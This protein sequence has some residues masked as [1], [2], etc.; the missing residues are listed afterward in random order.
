[1]AERT[2]EKI[3]ETE[4]LGRKI[5]MYGSIENPLFLARDVADW[6]DYSKRK[7]GSYQTGNMLKKVDPDEK[8]VNV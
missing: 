6:I 2:L 5:T 1:M 8:T 4:I 7:D 3:A